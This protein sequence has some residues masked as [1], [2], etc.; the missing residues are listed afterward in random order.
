LGQSYNVLEDL[1]ELANISDAKVRAAAVA[2]FRQGGM[3]PAMV[4]IFSTEEYTRVLDAAANPEPDFR[5]RRLLPV[6]KALKLPEELERL[7][8]WL[9][10]EDA[11]VRMPE[12]LAVDG[13]AHLRLA[14][15]QTL[16]LQPTPGRR[17][18]LERL[19]NDGDSAV[20]QAA[21]QALKDVATL[22]TSPLPT[23]Q[24]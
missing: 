22:R 3:L 17:E 2:E 7:I 16:A 24:R 5:C 20:Q 18:L 13:D 14:A 10:S 21:Q 15:A 11:P 9:K 1:S 23:S 6:V 19:T 8:H 4:G 12:L